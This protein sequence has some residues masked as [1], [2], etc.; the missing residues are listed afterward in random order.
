MQAYSA[1]NN[2]KLNP[3]VRNIKTNVDETILTKQIYIIL[4]YNKKQKRKKVL[5]FKSGKNEIF[6]GNCVFDC[7]RNINSI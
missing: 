6:S 4:C 5:F 1:L 2:Q 7:E 3:I